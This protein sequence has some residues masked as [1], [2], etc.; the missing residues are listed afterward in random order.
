MKTE[1]NIEETKLLSV[2][3]NEWVNRAFN[4]CSN[5]I[6]TQK[7][8]TGIEWLYDRFLSLPKPQVVYCDSIVDAVLKIT[9]IKDYDKELSDFTPQLLQDWK[10]GKLETEF[11][12]KFKDNLN[13]KSTYIGWSNFGWV[14]FYDYFTRIGVINNEDFNK[15]QTL[16]E[17]NVFET[18]EFENVVFAVKPPLKVSYNEQQ[19]SH[20]I[21]GPS[22]QFVDG[23]D[24]YT[25]NGFGVSKEFFDKLYNQEYTS[26]DFFRE[27]NEEKKSAVISFIQS[28]DGDTGV[29]H[30]LK[31]SLKE[32]DTYV[33]K[34]SPEMLVGT[35]NS[36][37]VG[38][39][40]LFK[41]EVNDVEIAYVR[42]Y[43]PSTDRI[44]F[45]GVDPSNTTAKNSI[46]SL[47]QVPK[48]LRN[49]IVS[50]SRQGEKFSTQFDDETT[51]K[52]KNGLFSNEEL[53]DYVSINGDDYFGLMVYE[54]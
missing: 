9:L 19:I 46:A 22:I 27:S 42:C 15:Y 16:I 45:L 4:E 52:I 41:G 5:G 49:N 29:Y 40:T 50:I 26:E 48:I 18:F 53:S 54:Y 51:E 35:V 1:L 30:F 24:Y 38:V 2:V 28:R 23:T 31:E 11:N 25:I 47:Y 21:E 37:N 44:F 34:K 43:C 7:F 20:S 32:V 3:R 8:E 6:D 10:D 14:S 39:Y 33:D 13:L 17:S 12:N 36:P